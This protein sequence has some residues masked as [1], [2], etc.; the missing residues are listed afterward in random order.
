[1][2]N[3]T[4]THIRLINSAREQRL[5][6]VAEQLR[7]REIVDERVLEAM[8][9][10]PRESFVPEDLIAE[11]YDDCP[12]PIGCSQT[13]SQPFTVAFMC[14]ALQLTG[15]EVVLEIGTGSGYGA[16]VLAS[17]AKTVYTIE[18]IPELAESAAKRLARLGYDNVHVRAGDGTLGWPDASPFEGIVVTAG[19]DTLPQPYVDQLA[20]GGR[21]VIPL[22]TYPWGQAMYRFTKT[23][24]GMD[25]ENLGGFTFVPLIGKHGWSNKE[26]A[27]TY[28]H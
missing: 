13:I 16:A 19:G 4:S 7:T 24:A 15:E 14:Q 5:R 6:M 23:A 18:R 3:H 17:L 20:L 10:V 26:V 27:R 11:A 1:M 9:H 8:S 2:T 21:I 22:G 12:L 28:W 25:S